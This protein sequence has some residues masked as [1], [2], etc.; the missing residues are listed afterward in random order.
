MKRSEIVQDG[1]LILRYVSAAAP[2]ENLLRRAGIASWL[3]SDPITTSSLDGRGSRPEYYPL[4]RS[5]MALTKNSPTKG[6]YDEEAQSSC[7][8]AVGFAFDRCRTLSGIIECSSKSATSNQ[9]GT[10]QPSGDDDS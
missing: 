5:V 4:P 6:V 10:G 9:I 1:S 2:Q 3:C 8:N 7:D